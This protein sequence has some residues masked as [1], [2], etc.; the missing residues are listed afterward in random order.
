[1]EPVNKNPLDNWD[2]GIALMLSAASALIYESG[3]MQV[4]F[5]YF[6]E[7]SYSLA[8]V[9][10]VFLGGLGIGSFLFYKLSDRLK[11]KK[12]LFGMLQI[13]TAIYAFTVLTRLTVIIP[14]IS[15]LGVFLVS[16]AILIIPA[17]FFG[18]IFPL[19][20][21]LLKRVNRETVGLVYSIDLLG[22]IVGALTVGFLV[23]PVWGIT[24]AMQLGA[25]L[26]LASGVLVMPRT[27]KVF[28]AAVAATF[29]S[30]TTFGNVPNPSVAAPSAKP[31]DGQAYQ[32]YEN[33]PYGP[34]AVQND[35]LYINNRLQCPYNPHPGTSQHAIVGN[36]LDQLKD[37]QSLKVLNIGLGCG[38]TLGK[39]L[40]YPNT[41]VD[42]VEINPVVI[43]ITKQ[44]SNVLENSRVNLI[45]GD[46]LELLRQTSQTYDSVIII[47]D[48]PLVAY[49]SPL[50]TVDAFRLAGRAL[51]PHGTLALWSFDTLFDPVNGQAGTTPTPPRY[52][53]ILYYSLKEVFP[54]VYK[55]Y[56]V[57]VG[58]N[59]KLDQPEYA[60]TT[61]YQVNTIDRNTLAGAY[62]GKFNEITATDDLEK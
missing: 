54:Y 46:G 28:A 40:E 26:N 12:L 44:F 2:I 30:L 61:P 17:I 4:L 33:S 23:I 41:Q 52:K 42:V 13:V 60:P 5:F 15:P 19:A 62:L 3:A 45:T 16:S 55:Y 56:K 39:V 47:V 48:S 9:L 38:G 50:Y 1:M 49:S 7:S 37:H 31:I 43:K 11:D 58:S 36:A 32:V 57:F 51:A 35:N 27:K 20:A 53:D 59:T 34:V 22:S 29:L 21:S 25:V 6:T 18:A 24:L 10:G 8:T 14:Q